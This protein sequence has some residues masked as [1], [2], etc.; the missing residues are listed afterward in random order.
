M[1]LVLL[2]SRAQLYF[3]PTQPIAARVADLLPRMTVQEKIQQTWTTHSSAATAKQ[4][5]KIGV[6]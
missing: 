2:S 5:T 1:L 3:D 4:W 6:R